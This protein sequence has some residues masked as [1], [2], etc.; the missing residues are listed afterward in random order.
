[1]R[2]VDLHAG[3]GLRLVQVATQAVVVRLRL[4]S[5]L[6]GEIGL[7]ARTLG[8]GT[9]GLGLHTGLVRILFLHRKLAAEVLLFSLHSHQLLLQLAEL[10]LHG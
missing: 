2:P 6:D 10:I 1:M 4:H 3:R 8:L 9:S 7:R 5:V